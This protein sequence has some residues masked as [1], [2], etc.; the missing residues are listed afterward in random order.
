MLLTELNK[1]V[2]SY[3][4]SS[5]M[6]T[7]APTPTPVALTQPP[8]GKAGKDASPAPSSGSVNGRD[9]IFLM[10]ALL[11]EM[12]NTITLTWSEGSEADVTA[13]IHHF[14]LKQCTAYAAKC[15]LA[16]DKLPDLTSPSVSI[17][18]GSVSTH[19][20]PSAAPEGFMASLASK[21]FANG[22]DYY[23]TAGGLFSHVTAF[24]LL[25]DKK[26]TNAAAAA[27]AAAASAAPPAKG[28]KKEDP[29]KQVAA[30]PVES[31]QPVLTK[32]M[33][34]RVDLRSI[35]K[36][37]RDVRDKYL[38]VLPKSVTLEIRA[39][40]EKF[41]DLV[42]SLVWL[43]QNGTMYVPGSAANTPISPSARLGLPVRAE[44]EII[45]KSS[46]EFSVTL[47]FP[48]DHDDTE[49]EEKEGGGG[50]GGTHSISVPI[51]E[52]F[53]LNLA[54]VLSPGVALDS[55][56]DNDVCQLLRFSLGYE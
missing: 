34:P 21:A 26:D 31:V 2:T 27:A 32:V 30:T 40:N 36:Q 13:D 35:E 15:V 5:V 33:L 29:S 9:A 56:L 49:G 4:T 37:L 47:T 3:F 12:D 43:L 44:S 23:S 10:G 39:C 55:L 52:K 41:S 18:I 42:V 6:D 17:P 48:R 22:A 38:D 51:N 25:G 45:E 28:A 46:A 20:S 11:R 7:G 50:G 54:N 53:M 8:K 16:P 24:L 14:L 19:W 1:I